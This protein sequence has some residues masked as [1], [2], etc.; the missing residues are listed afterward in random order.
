MLELNFK[1]LPDLL[2]HFPDDASARAYFE[3]ER[4]QGV[5]TCP[6]CGCD[7]YYKLNT[8]KHYKC[9]NKQCHKKYSVT[10]GT[11]FE[12]SHIPLN[13]WFAAIY[14]IS[15]HKKGIS[16]YQLGKDISVTQK[17]A[18]FMLH[19]IR[20]MFRE[21]QHELLNDTVE[22]DETYMSRKYHSER[23]PK[24]F[25]YTPSW[26]NIRDKGCVLGM[27][28]RRGK[29]IVKV[30]E[31]ASGAP[32]KAAIK[33]HVAKNSTLYTDDS[34]IYRRGLEDYLRD[35]VTHSA[36][37]YV[38]GDVHTNNIENF[39]GIMKRGIYGIYHQISFK[40]LQRY[41]DEFTFRHNRRTLADNERFILSL[42]RPEGRLKYAQLIS[43]EPQKE[44]PDKEEQ[45]P[46]G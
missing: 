23:K 4:W 41:C 2:R 17:T 5:P 1:G 35:S 10:V 39:W 12:S 25:D 8:G 13:I 24:E 40:H 28:Q 36:K 7:K 18:W 29:I 20:E 30:F 11:I 38:R 43:N 22:V 19:R 37:E 21:K 9:G 6:Y 3:A 26:P 31:G 27:I 32:I 33:K 34:Y 45:N 44:E 14:V 46:T 16:S 42:L 15:S